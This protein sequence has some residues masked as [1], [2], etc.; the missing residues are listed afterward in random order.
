MG[1]R[2]GF[3]YADPTRRIILEAHSYRFGLIVG[4][5][6]ERAGVLINDEEGGTPQRFIWL[7][8]TDPGITADPPPTPQPLK[9][10]A[11]RGQWQRGHIPIPDQVAREIREA[12]VARHQGDGDALDG[13]ALFS[14]EKVA[15]ALALLDNRREMNLDDWRLAAII[16][17]KS[18]TVRAAVIKALNKKAKATETA[19]ALSEGRREVIRSQVVAGADLERACQAITRKLRREGGWVA[20]KVA[21]DAI[22]TKLRHLFDE[23]VDKLQETGQ[24]D[25]EHVEYQGRSGIRLRIS[26]A[27]K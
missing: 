6:P 27:S 14:R 21:R 7:P 26:E 17:A 20:G 12:H 9:I 25:V 11:T 16:M 15:V 5:Q 22:P 3:S 24:I 1:E 10:D 23:A 2:L 18:D 13:H 8:A 19:R 4:V